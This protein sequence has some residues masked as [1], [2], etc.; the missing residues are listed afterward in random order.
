MLDLATNPAS[1]VTKGR[2]FGSDAHEVA[3]FGVAFSR[4]LS[5]E[6]VLA[7][8]K[9][10][11]GHGDAAVDPHLDLARFDGSHE[12]LAQQELVPFAAAIEAGVPLIMTAHILL[13]QLDA[14]RPASISSILLKQVLRHDLHFEGVVLADDLGMGA[15]AKRYGPGESAVKA[16][17]AGTDIVMLCHDWSGV[18]PA[19]D[20]VAK[21]ITDGIFDAAQWSQASERIAQS[22]QRLRD[23]DSPAP[24]V[25]IIGCAEHHT[26]AAEAR[27]RLPFS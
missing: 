9:H 2:S 22:R 19:V 1:P 17:Q 6:G 10:F 16:L 3:R 27:S 4:G 26:L 12:R 7:C 23:L 11:P 24:P 13:P 5:A 18:A 15:I 20:A 21:G 8:A 14:D 25:E